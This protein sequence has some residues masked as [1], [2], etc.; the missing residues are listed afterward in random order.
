MNY[1]PNSKKHKASHGGYKGKP[2]QA[3]VQANISLWASLIPDGYKPLEMNVIT[4]NSCEGKS[5]F[6]T[7]IDLF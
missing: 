1:N 6:G 2:T 7:Q 4:A 3:Q 5:R